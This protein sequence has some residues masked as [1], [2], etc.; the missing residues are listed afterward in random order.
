MLTKMYRLPVQHGLTQYVGRANVPLA[1][2]TEKLPKD[3]RLFSLSISFGLLVIVFINRRPQNCYI[4]LQLSELDLLLQDIPMPTIDYKETA[5]GVVVHLDQKLA[6]KIIP[7]EGGHRYVPK[8]HRPSAGGE[9]FP[10]I[11]EVKKTLEPDYD[12]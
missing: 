9:I 3:W 12:D 6:G 8:G 1:L 4:T 11:A 7:V 2:R 5:S 10:T